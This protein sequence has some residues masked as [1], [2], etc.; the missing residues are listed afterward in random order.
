MLITATATCMAPMEIQEGKNLIAYCRKKQQE[1]LAF[2]I[3]LY[4][5]DSRETA[6]KAVSHYMFCVIFSEY[7]AEIEAIKNDWRRNQYNQ[8]GAYI[9]PVPEMFVKKFAKRLFN[10]LL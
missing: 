10:K 9:A 6:T 4:F 7:G 5:N 3:N 2:F 1:A 8:K